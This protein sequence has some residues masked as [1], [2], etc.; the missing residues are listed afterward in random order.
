MMNKI[1]FTLIGVI[2]GSI[3]SGVFVGMSCAKTYKK[4]IEDL[5][6]DNEYLRDQLHSQKKKDIQERE[7]K[8]RKDEA[9]IDASLLA[10][11]TMAREEKEKTAEMVKRHGYSV[12]DEE[13]DEDYDINEDVEFDDPFDEGESVVVKKPIEK[14]LPMF[15]MMSQEDYEQDFEYR[16]AENLTYYQ[17]DHVLADSFDDRIGNAVEIVGEEALRE[18]QETNEDFIYV[19]DEVE[20]KMYEIEINHEESYYRDAARGGVV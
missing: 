17:A 3:A 20:D 9:E 15:S 16:D 18:A 6:A 10:Q 11:L 13:E 1:I 7:E 14:K 12:A 19:L 4:Q 5:E 2:V 8:A